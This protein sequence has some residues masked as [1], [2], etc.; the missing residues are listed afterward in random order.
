MAHLLVACVARG[1]ETTRYSR[2]AAIRF[3]F[4]LL[5]EHIPAALNYAVIE[6]V[7]GPWIGPARDHAGV[8]LRHRHFHGGHAGGEY[9]GGR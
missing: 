2:T 5:D 1:H 6:D 4:Y 8:I 7:P 9:P 3:L